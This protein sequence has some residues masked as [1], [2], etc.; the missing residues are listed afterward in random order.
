M[1]SAIFILFERT[2][3]VKK[4]CQM[5]HFG[6]IATSRAPVANLTQR[7]PGI[8]D[9]AKGKAKTPVLGTRLTWCYGCMAFMAVKLL[10]RSL[11]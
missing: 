9:L 4:S 6:L 5:I 7:D 11:Q 8:L 3:M 2:S 1:R 10:D